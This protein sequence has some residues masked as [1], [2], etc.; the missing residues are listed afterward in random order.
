MRILLFFLFKVKPSVSQFSFPSHLTQ[1]MRIIV[2][3]NVLTGDPPIRIDWLHNNRT[4]RFESING[5][6][7]NN[8]SLERSDISEVGSSLV[9]RQVQASHRGLYTCRASNAAGEDQYSAMMTVKC[10]HHNIFLKNLIFISIYAIA[11]LRVFTAAP[12]WTIEPHDLDAVLG[13]SVNFDCQAEGFPE[14]LIRWKMAK[15]LHVHKTEY[16]CNSN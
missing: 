16:F 5:R 7:L 3:C 15:G 9:F 14:P 1:G 8:H 13:E 4:I 10:K 11:F 2:T 6:F 12:R